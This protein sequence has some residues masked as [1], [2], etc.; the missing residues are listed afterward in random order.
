M[1]LSENKGKRL[2]DIKDRT[3][4][5]QVRTSLSDLHEPGDARALEKWYHDAC[6]ILA[7]RSCK[8]VEAQNTIR[9]SR[10][11]SDCEIVVFVRESLAT[12]KSL[13]MSEV[14]EV[15]IASLNDKG[16]ETAQTANYK[17]HLKEL[18]KQKL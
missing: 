15:Y 11:M 16:I 2:V 9:L 8:N 7:D 17:V 3:N 12:E 4:D 1:V 10:Y 18:L 14:N 5:D 13:T 6:M